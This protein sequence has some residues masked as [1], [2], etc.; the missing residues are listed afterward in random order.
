MSA[1]EGHVKILRWNTYR[2]AWCLG[3]LVDV[4]CYFLRLVVG[5][6]RLLV[7]VCVLLLLVVLLLGRP[8]ALRK[9]ALIRTRSRVSQF[10]L[11]GPGLHVPEFDA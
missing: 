6:L 7:L 10:Q 5:K 2:L 3:F 9:Q 8:C 4:F 1:L 11:Q